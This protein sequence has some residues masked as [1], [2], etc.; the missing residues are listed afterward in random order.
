[1]R[2][3]RNAFDSLPED[4]Q[5]NM[6]E[7]NNE[8]VLMETSQPLAGSLRGGPR[9]AATFSEKLWRRHVRLRL[10]LAKARCGVHRGRRGVWRALFQ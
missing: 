5:W 10:P 2:N 9:F 6:E 8:T 3:N 4:V 1:M 7:E